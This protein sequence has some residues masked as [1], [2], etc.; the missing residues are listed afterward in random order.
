[1]D[2]ASEVVIAP[3]QSLK[4]PL[5]FVSVLSFTFTGSSSNFLL[6]L[7]LMVVV[8]KPQS[9]QLPDNRH[10]HR[11]QRPFLLAYFT[12]NRIDTVLP[13]SVVLKESKCVNLRLFF[14]KLL[15][16]TVWERWQWHQCCHDRHQWHINYQL[17]TICIQIA[18]TA[19]SRD[20]KLLLLPTRRSRY[21]LPNVSSAY[22]EH[23]VFIFATAV[24]AM[25]VSAI[26]KA[27]KHQICLFFLLYRT[28]CTLRFLTFSLSSL[29]VSF[30]GCFS[31][32]FAFYE[33]LAVTLWPPISISFNSQFRGCIY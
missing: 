28:K 25:T 3:R 19:K 13:L 15:K 21:W 7:M 17:S 23:R 4:S 16:V 20:T 18:T 30:Y 12:L 11:S 26:S 32:S 2:M 24:C 9:T 29:D 10:S 8:N 1:M 5:L 22:H 33:P 14:F 6:Q 27:V 31:D